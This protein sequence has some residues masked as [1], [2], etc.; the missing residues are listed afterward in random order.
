MSGRNSFSSNSF[1]R[2]EYRIAL[3]DISIAEAFR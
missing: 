1:V 2:D 3:L